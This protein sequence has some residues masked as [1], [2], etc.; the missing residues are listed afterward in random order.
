MPRKIVGKR[1]G[2]EPQDEREHFIKCAACGQWIDMRDLGEVLD[3]ERACDTRAP[4]PH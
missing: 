2:G 4:P 3:H 1:R